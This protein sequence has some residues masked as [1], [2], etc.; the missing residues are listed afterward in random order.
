MENALTSS[1][2]KPDGFGWRFLRWTRVGFISRRRNFPGARPG[3]RFTRIPVFSRRHR[4]YICL[5]LS[6]CKV[7]RSADCNS[8]F[9][10]QTFTRQTSCRNAQVRVSKNWADYTILHFVDFVMT[11][12]APSLRNRQSGVWMEY[13]FA[14]LDKMRPATL[15]MR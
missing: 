11:A 1:P 8:I 4:R 6:A 2:P 7:S 3:R 10:V 5:Q 13:S 12:Q 15:P 14:D 9:S